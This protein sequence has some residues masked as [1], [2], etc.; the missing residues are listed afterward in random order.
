MAGLGWVTT[1]GDASDHRI[2]ADALLSSG[3]GMARLWSS[4]FS[5]Q[6]NPRSPDSMTG[7]FCLEGTALVTTAGKRITLSSR[8]GFFAPPGSS[9]TVEARDNV[10]LQE[11]SLSAEFP[12]RYGL[13]V[14]DE[15]VF[16]PSSN[17]I[18]RAL[19]GLA[20]LVHSS[21]ASDIDVFPFL[22]TSVENMIAATLVGSMG[23]F[24]ASAD[25][26]TRLLSEARG[27][28]RRR[29]LERGFG[30]TVLA[31]E[32]R[33]SPRTI[34]LAFASAGT[35]VRDSIRV[36]RT[37]AAREMLA[38][39]EGA[40]HTDLVHVARLTGFS[41]VRA[42]QRALTKDQGRNAAEGRMPR[43]EAG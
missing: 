38:V 37:R 9:F 39:I 20:G 41:D 40:S 4:A 24:D 13:E 7:L 36:A 26:T 8:D 27:S 15:S 10:A 33:V 11:F 6:R 23:R 22:R 1:S 35:T 43:G 12:Y 30:V 3:F 25:A 14:L 2:F 5:A 31:E 21:D 17:S 18:V 16:I 32:L 34:Q 42:L 19:L 29:A 28:I